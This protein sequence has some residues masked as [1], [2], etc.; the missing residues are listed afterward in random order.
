MSAVYFIGD[1][2]WGHR[3][4][5]KYRPEFSSV[6]E[7]DEVI[8]DNI[9]SVANRRNHLWL[10][11]DCFFN[12]ESVRHLDRIAAAFAAVKFVVGNHDTD[13]D[14]RQEVLKRVIHICTKVHSLVKYRE[15]WLSHAPIHTCELRGRFNV[16]GHMHSQSVG[17]DRY[18]CVSCEQVDYKPVTLEQVRE[19][20]VE[21][22]AY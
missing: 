9:M 1:T 7:H 20:F 16:H 15:F 3:N 11:G 19:K 8:F 18:L 10:M 4:I 5:L 2:H 21:R 17:D 6:E 22:G 13:N 12:H 14:E